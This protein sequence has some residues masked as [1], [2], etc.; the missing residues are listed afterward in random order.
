MKITP[1]FIL[2]I[3]IISGCADIK[4]PSAHYALTHPLGTKTMVTLGTDKEE[5]LEKWGE[6]D[7][8]REE[9]YDDAG[10]KKEAWVYEAWFAQAPL[11]YRH[12]SRKKCIYFTDDYVTGFEDIE[13]IEDTEDAIEDE[14]TL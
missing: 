1:I 2:V 14:E 6:P 7:E 9:G 11:D 10:L 8:I 3:F 13:N 5:V 12:F 4:T